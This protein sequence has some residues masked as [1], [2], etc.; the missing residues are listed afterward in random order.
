MRRKSPRR[1][2]VNGHVRKQKP[3]RS[4]IRGRGANNPLVKRKISPI[5]VSKQL[6]LDLKPYCKKIE[7]AGSIRRGKSNP[8]DVDLL[9]IPKNK[10][11]LEKIK[12]YGEI[13]KNHMRLKGDKIISFGKHG[14]Q[15]DIYVAE[16]DSFGAM[17]MFLTGPGGYNIAYRRIAKRQG[18]LLNQYGLFDRKTN[19]RLAGKTEQSIYKALGRT[20][21]PPELRGK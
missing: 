7:I 10:Q 6:L 2:V 9:L 14:V 4:Y 18:M 21:K 13:Q 15:V 3:V 1:H 20:Y 12:H 19:R 16:S 17:E 11:A 5:Q 8:K